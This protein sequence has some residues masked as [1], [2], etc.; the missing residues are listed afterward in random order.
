MASKGDVF[1]WDDEDEEAI[2]FSPIKDSAYSAHSPPKPEDKELFSLPSLVYHVSP[3]VD[4]EE[5]CDGITSP[6]PKPRAPESIPL[7]FSSMEDYLN[8]MQSHLVLEHNF[9]LSD[10]LSQDFRRTHKFLPPSAKVYLNPVSEEVGHLTRARSVRETSSVLDGSPP[11]DPVPIYRCL[12]RT[13]PSGQ[14]NFVVSD[15]DGFVSFLREVPR[16]DLELFVVDY[17]GSM[18]A[19]YDACSTMMSFQ[20]PSDLHS[21][22]K[23]PFL[24]N[25]KHCGNWHGSQ[26]SEQRF[27]ERIRVETLNKVLFI[28]IFLIL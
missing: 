26:D 12:V 24:E 8:V 7:E 22:F 25:H 4:H 28:V 2:P 19:N 15:D 14:L 9:V 3:N 17:C 5:A 11:D 10:I 23:K 20:G 16:D 6:I 18:I 1:G 21:A 27:Q 13:M